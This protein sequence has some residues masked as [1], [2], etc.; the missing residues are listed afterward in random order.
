MGHLEIQDGHVET[1]LPEPGHRLLSV[2]GRSRFPRFALQPP[3]E[4]LQQLEVVIGDQNPGCG[5]V[6]AGAPADRRPRKVGDAQIS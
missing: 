5:V 1:A 6:H 4:Q 2:G 3:P